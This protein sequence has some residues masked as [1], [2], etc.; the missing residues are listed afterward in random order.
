[1]TRRGSAPVDEIF[2]PGLQPERTLLAWRRTALAL[3]VGCAAVVRFAAPVVGPVVVVAGL[4]G[5]ALCGA[6]Y[7]GAAA[8]YRRV[9]GELVA[10]GSTGHGVLTSPGA[11]CAALTTALLLVGAG[12]LAFVVARAAAH[13]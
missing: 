8:Q 9:S 11:A 1:M 13:G 7:V 3:A 4:V 5:L 10:R 6:A 2:D 12:A